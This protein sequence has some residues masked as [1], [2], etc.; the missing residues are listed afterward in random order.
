MKNYV[1]RLKSFFN[2]C[3]IELRAFLTNSK[4]E[5]DDGAIVLGQVRTSQNGFFKA[6]KNFMLGEGAVLNVFNGGSLLIGDNVSIGANTTFFVKS[7]VSVDDCVGF[8][9]SCFLT[10]FDHDFEVNDLFERRKAFITKEVVVRNNAFIGAQS[11]VLK[12]VTIG[13]HSVV[14]ANSTVVDDVESYTIVAG[15]PAKFI[16]LL[17]D[18]YYAFDNY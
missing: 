16:K 7:K 6:G 4:V 5:F 14:G 1:V 18:G 17:K 10:D 12:G 13:K 8:G 9:P 2:L 15:N 11:V 3:K